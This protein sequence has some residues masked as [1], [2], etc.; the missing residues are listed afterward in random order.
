MG[1][2]RRRGCQEG[3]GIGPALAQ[4][5]RRPASGT[6]RGRRERDGL[7]GGVGGGR[8]PTAAILGAH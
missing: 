1:G 2:G 3:I 4:P 6:H 5:L 8:G 7:G